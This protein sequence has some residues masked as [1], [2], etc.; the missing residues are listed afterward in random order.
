MDYVNKE[1][2]ELS[3]I[4]SKTYGAFVQVPYSWY[5]LCRKYIVP[6]NKKKFTD[7][8]KGIVHLNLAEINVLAYLGNFT[9]CYPTNGMIAE[10]FNV[11]KHTIEKYIKELKL[12]GFIKTHEVKD[13]PTHTKRRTIYV[14][15]DTIQEV[16]SSEAN[17]YII[18]HIYD[19]GT[20]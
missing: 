12:V 3:G 5:K 1:R 4:L 8:G 2:N 9:E 19:A 18:P 14:Q 10:V 15:H 13:S 16:I 20:S 6:E 7:N 11:R 17:P